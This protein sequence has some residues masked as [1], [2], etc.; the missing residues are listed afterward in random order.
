M[1]GPAVVARDLTRRFGGFTA[2]DRVSFEVER[3]EIFGYLGANGAG[4]STTIR[5]LTGLLAPS[6]GEARVAG[7]DVLAQPERVK[8]AIGYMSQKFSLYLDLPAGENLRFFAGAQGLAGRARAVR[9]EE[10][11]ERVGLRG[12]EAEPTGALP[13]GARQRLALGCAI[14]HRPEVLF[15]DEPTAGVDPLAR[16]DFW[17]LIREL[18]AGGTTVFVTTHYLDE[19]EYCRRI[20]LMVDGRLVAL[21]SPAA[22][23]ARW[24]PGVVLVARGRGLAPEALRRLP[25]V[26]AAEPFGAGLHVRIDPAR[27]APAQVETALR[28]AGAQ[29]LVLAPAAPSLEDVFLAVVGGGAGPEAPRPLPG[30]PPLRGRGEEGG[31]GSEEDAAGTE[32]GLRPADLPPRRAGR[33]GEGRPAGAATPAAPGRAARFLGRVAAMSFKEALHI[34]RDPRTLY[35]ALVMPV[36]MLLLFGYGVSFD[37][38]HLR[39]AVADADRT[40]ASRALVRAFTTAGEFDRVAEVDPDRADDVFRRAR[41]AA[42]LVVP[43]GYEERLAGGRPAQA[44]L[45]VDGSDGNTANQILAKADAIARDEARRLA[46]GAARPPLEVQVLT[47]YNPGGRSAVYLVPGLAAYLLAI[48]AVLLTALTVA[49]E[50][51]RGSMEQLFASPVSR[52]EIVLGKLLPYLAIG[53]VQLLL[54]IAVG[55]VVFEVPIVGSVALLFALGLLFLAGMLAQGLLISVVTRNQLVATQAGA[56]SSLL[57]SML[58]SGMLFP[59]ENMPAPLRA[60][61]RVVPARYLVHGLRGAMLKGNGLAVLWPD[62]LALAVFAVAVVALATARFQRRLA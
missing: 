56:L 2:V 43:R 11:L 46:G 31:A 62:L 21:D 38:D 22:L 52:L 32:R 30:P 14:L 54:V 39:L 16:R 10:V 19:A 61:S 34:R 15:L 33:A 50:W 41:A 5:M 3:G 36:V 35:L 49:G 57:P 44:E 47:R 42:V 17:A 9:A 45:L 18:A 51:E 58:L 25:G 28:G 29:G 27:L 12:R 8:S 13:G 4:K 6:G 23:K 48:A 20:G 60:L 59:I 55:A 1:S 26:L 24:V 40:A 37:V 7:H 53:L